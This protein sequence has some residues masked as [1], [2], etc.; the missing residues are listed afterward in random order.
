MVW[1]FPSK[2][3]PPFGRLLMVSNHTGCDLLLEMLWPPV[4]ILQTADENPADHRK[5]LAIRRWKYSG[6][7]LELPRRW[8]FAVRLWNF[9][10]MHWNQCCDPWSESLRSDYGS[11][12]AL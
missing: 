9:A 11:L 5:Y 4:E 12:A 3:L 10:S 2:V 8:K 7:P 6:P 1:G